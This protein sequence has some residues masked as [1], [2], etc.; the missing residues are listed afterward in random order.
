[1][2]SLWAEPRTVH[3]VSDLRQ[4]AWGSA[5][6]SSGWER[7][8]RLVLSGSSCSWKLQLLEAPAPESSCV[9]GSWYWESL[10]GDEVGQPQ[11]EGSKRWKASMSR[12]LLGE[13][14]ET[15][16]PSTGN[17][18]KES[19]SSDAS[20]GEGLRGPWGVT[21]EVIEVEGPRGP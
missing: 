17:T 15:E 8:G 19:S 4:M 21:L 14:R 18:H 1:M 7:E 6:A 13:P 20:P 5:W 2:S 9:E 16:V 3:W 12:F 11:E 10:W